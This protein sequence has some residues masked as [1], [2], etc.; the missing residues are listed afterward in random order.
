MKK[1]KNQ[2]RLIIGTQRV[3][4]SKRKRSVQRPPILRHRRWLSTLNPCNIEPALDSPCFV[5]AL[6]LSSPLFR[7]AVPAA[8][9]FVTR[10]PRSCCFT[11]AL[12]S[13][14]PLRLFVS[15]C[16]FAPPLQHDRAFA[17][18]GTRVTP[19][20]CIPVAT[21][22]EQRPRALCVDGDVAARGEVPQIRPFSGG[23]HASSLCKLSRFCRICFLGTWR[24][25]ALKRDESRVVYLYV[26]VHL[27]LDA[28]D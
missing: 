15:A 10:R 14:D 20:E 1:K 7:G 23:R 28:F 13:S 9:Y 24:W 27:N 6:R 22:G 25:S 4:A 8:I 2:A 5:H 26:C 17:V 18:G 3:S 21:S 11:S 12:S 16:A 19:W